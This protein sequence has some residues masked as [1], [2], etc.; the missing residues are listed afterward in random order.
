MVKRL[1]IT[2]EAKRQ[3]IS[4]KNREAA[5]IERQRQMKLQLYQAA[6][7]EEEQKELLKEQ[8]TT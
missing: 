8:K 7:A 1:G 6:K 5:E 4:N 2:S 3:M